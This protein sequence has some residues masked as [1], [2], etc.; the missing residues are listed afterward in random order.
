MTETTNEPIHLVEDEATGDRFLVYGSGKG[1]RLDI[2]FR[3][4]LYG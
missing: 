4:K 3:V 1:M 2:R